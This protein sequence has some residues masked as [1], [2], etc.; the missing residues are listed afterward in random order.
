MW[1]ITVCW[2]SNKEHSML[3]VEGKGSGVIRG[4]FYVEMLSGII[5]LKIPDNI[6]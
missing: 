1:E 6:P 2:I 4:L 3:T 5:L